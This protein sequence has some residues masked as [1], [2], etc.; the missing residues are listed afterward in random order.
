MEI[1]YVY[2]QTAAG[3]D[4]VG[5]YLFSLPHGYSID[6]GKVFVNSDTQLHSD[7]GPASIF[8]TNSGIELSIGYM[9]PYDATHLAMMFP[10]EG[11]HGIVTWGYFAAGSPAS[12]VSSPFSLK[13]FAKVPILGWST[14]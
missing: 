5:T 13:F 2:H 6:T 9:W 8:P 14:R 12:F 1:S 7:V 10:V 4:G 3:T 11:S